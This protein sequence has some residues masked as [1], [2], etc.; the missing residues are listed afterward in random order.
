[1]K[2]LINIREF[3]IGC[4]LLL[5]IT[6]MALF[7]P[8]IATHDPRAL[9]DE[10]L[11]PPSKEYLL[12]TDHLGRDVFSMLLYGAGTSLLVGV[13][14]AIISTI[15]GVLIGAIS[16]YY[17]GW[18]DRI[19]SEII[20]MFM[21]IPTFFLIIICVALYGSSMKNVVI[22]IALTSWMGTARMMRAET[23]SLKERDFVRAS[24][25]AGEED[26]YIIF[27]HILPH[28][29]YPIIVNAT[30]SSSSAILYEASL[31][32]LGLGDPQAISWG[33]I[34]YNGKPYLINGW[35]ISTFAGLFL[36]IIVYAFHMI[37]EGINKSMIEVRL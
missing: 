25:V 33:Q 8:L 28:G 35:W 14:A 6:I 30:L 2:K 36:A 9:N 5:L 4:I 34:I 17:G 22:V 15:I 37:A 19:I 29:L 3:K 16:G 21:M 32:F 31:S 26:I 10:L 7:A 12:G 23:L 18:I 1:M 27:R 20:N 13:V 11:S 24:L